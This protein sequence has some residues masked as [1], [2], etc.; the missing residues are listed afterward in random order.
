MK[1]TLIKFK[2]LKDKYKKKFLK[3]NDE[4]EIDDNQLILIPLTELKDVV[5]R[6]VLK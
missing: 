3:E 5:K 1:T 2:E 6:S 4:E